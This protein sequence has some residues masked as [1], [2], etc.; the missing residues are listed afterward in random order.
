MRIFIAGNYGKRRGASLFERHANVQKMIGA[1]R[2]RL[3]KGHNVYVPNLWHF[4]DVGWEQGLSEPEYFELGLEWLSLCDALYLM[5]DVYT[6]G[7]G[8]LIE[9][10]VAEAL[11][12]A[13]YTKLEDIPD[14]N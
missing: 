4:L 2:E 9:S 13:I 10:G 14:G 1:A 6:Q 12:K 7:S 8:A 3:K 5:P 11:G